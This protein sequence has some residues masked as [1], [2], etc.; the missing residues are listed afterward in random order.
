MLS[1]H[2]DREWRQS[3]QELRYDFVRLMDKV[4]VGFADGRLKGPFHIDGQSVILEDYLE[5]RP[6]Q[7]GLINDLASKGMLTI[8]P[9]YALPDEFCVSGESLIRNLCMGRNIARSFGYEPSNVGFASDMFGH[10]SQLPQIFTGFG[11][12]CAFIWRGLNDHKRN[13]LWQG[14][15]GTEIPCYRCGPAGYSSYAYYVG[16]MYDYEG[17]IEPKQFFGALEAYLDGEA[18]TSDIETL[19]IFDGSDHFQWNEQAYGLLCERMQQNKSPY[20]IIHTQIQ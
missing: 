8:G 12:S 19:L 18:K 9:W 7:R 16:R 14:A 13:I 2:W 11:I 10:I 5:V 1:T 3:F 17:E 4:L 15:D 6:E 20:E